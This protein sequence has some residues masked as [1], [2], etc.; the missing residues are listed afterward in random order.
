MNDY[1]DQVI[2]FKITTW[3]KLAENC[4]QFLFKGKQVYVEGR[5]QVDPET[6]AS[7][8]WTRGDGTPATSFEVTA[9]VVKFLSGNTEGEITVD[10]VVDDVPF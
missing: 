10:E 4:G 5:L 6:G 8:I 1:K 7:K 2:W 3:G 9:T